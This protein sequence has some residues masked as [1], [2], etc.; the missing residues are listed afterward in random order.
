M[1]GRG[2]RRR[3]DVRAGVRPRH[4][5][6]GAAA[7]RHRIRAAAFSI[8]YRKGGKRAGTYLNRDLVWQRLERE[9]LAGVTL[10]SLDDE[11]SAM[12][13]RPLEEV[14]RAS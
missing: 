3:A 2:D 9:G 13:L 14:G 5:R 12:R 8:S 10:V 6:A 7:Q 4:G 1:S 11:W